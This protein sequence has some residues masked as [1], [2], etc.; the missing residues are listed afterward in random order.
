MCEDEAQCGSSVCLYLCNGH[1]VCTKNGQD[2]LRCY[3]KGEEYGGLCCEKSLLP[4]LA[5][6]SIVIDPATPSNIYVGVDGQGVYRSTNSGAAWTAATTQPANKNIRALVIKP[7]AITQ[8]FAGTYGGGVNRSTNSGVDWGPCG[9]T[10]L[11]NLNVLS[12]V[13]SPTGTLYAGTENGVY[14]STDC[15]TWTALNTGLP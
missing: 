1:G 12:L 5:A 13:T 6:T 8:L 11:A 14:T 15:D 9:N 3:C 10:G 7:S 4:T 2:A